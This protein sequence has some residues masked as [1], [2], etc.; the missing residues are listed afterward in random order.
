LHRKPKAEVPENAIPALHLLWHPRLKNNWHTEKDAGREKVL[1]HPSRFC[2][3]CFSG[4]KDF[5]QVA[6]LV[7]TNSSFEYRILQL[8]IMIS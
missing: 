8:D 4:V 7:Q 2:K 3:N 5:S 6:L 1:C